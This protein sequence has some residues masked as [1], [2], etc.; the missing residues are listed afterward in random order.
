MTKYG[1]IQLTVEYSPHERDRIRA[2]ASLENNS[3][4]G[5]RNYTYGLFATHPKTNLD[6]K[7]RGGVYWMPRYYRT[8]HITYYKRSYLPM[9]SAE[10]LAMMDVNNNEIAFKV[11]DITDLLRCNKYRSATAKL[12][13]YH[14]SGRCSR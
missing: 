12:I 14:I 10:G 8:A 5:I 1:D 2:G 13:T 11:S 3:L 4:R 7:V 9:Q 6:L